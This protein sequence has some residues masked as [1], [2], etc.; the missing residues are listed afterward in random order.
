[1]RGG[2]SVLSDL[3]QIPQDLV[4][5][6]FN[7]NQGKRIYAYCAAEQKITEQVTVSYSALPVVRQHELSR[8]LGRLLMD[9]NPI[10]KMALGRPSYCGCGVVNR[11]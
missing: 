2:V 9:P 11:N 5:F 1:V 8:F 4:D 6:L 10:V 7:F 3:V